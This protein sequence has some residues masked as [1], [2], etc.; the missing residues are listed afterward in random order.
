VIGKLAEDEGDSDV[1]LNIMDTNERKW[2]KSHVIW[3]K[4]H[5]VMHENLLLGFGLCPLR[6]QMLELHSS[7]IPVV[8]CS[9]R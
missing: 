8:R 1:Q 6:S 4:Y 2:L 5:L 3:C 7:I 9:C